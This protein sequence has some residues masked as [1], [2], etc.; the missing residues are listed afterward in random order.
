MVFK[1]LIGFYAVIMCDVQI[2]TLIIPNSIKEKVKAKIKS[3]D[4]EILHNWK[5][6]NISPL[7]SIS[8]CGNSQSKS[9]TS[10]LICACKE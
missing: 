3:I 5:F 6:D 7:L 8:T 1:T 2:T 9:S 4:H 10:S